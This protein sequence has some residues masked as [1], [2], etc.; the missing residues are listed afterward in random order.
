MKRYNLSFL[1]LPVV[2]AALITLLLSADVQAQGG[3]GNWTDFDT[4]LYRF[5]GVNW[6]HLAQ[7][8]DSIR[9]M[10]VF[11]GELVIAGMFDSV[12]SEPRH[13][14]TSWDGAVFHDL[15]GGGFSEAG[16]A[17]IDHVASWDGV[18]WSDFAPGLGDGPT[19]L[20]IYNGEA[21]IA[22]GTP[23]HPTAEL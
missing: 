21:D 11:G 17:P 19:D 8:N 20:E 18:V 7:F 23:V 5:N 2:V 10:L 1:T 14:I 15:A 16:G 4:H 9:E 12:D 22:T 3:R 6:Q 13:F